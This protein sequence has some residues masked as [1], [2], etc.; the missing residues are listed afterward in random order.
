VVP[1]VDQHQLEAVGDTQLSEVLQQQ[2][3][4][5]RLRRGRRHHDA[6]DREVEAAVGE[7]CHVSDHLMLPLLNMD[8]AHPVR[9]SVGPVTVAAVDPLMFVVPTSQPFTAEQVE[10]SPTTVYPPET[11]ASRVAE[12]QASCGKARDRASAVAPVLQ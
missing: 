5:P 4:R 10:D 1:P 11:H 7:D 8:T 2:L 6:A 9:S 3:R 12:S